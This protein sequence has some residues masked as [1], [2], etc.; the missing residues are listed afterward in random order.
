[1]T[2]E[3][4]RELK[5]AESMVIDSL[6]EYSTFVQMRKGGARFSVVA[7]LNVAYGGEW[8]A[9][10]TDEEVSMIEN[11]LFMAARTATN[12]FEAL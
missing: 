11:R 5:L 1:M 10:L 12:V 9:W 6:D 3:K 8:I 4:L 7:A 2:A